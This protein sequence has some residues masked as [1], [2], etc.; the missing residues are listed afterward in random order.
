VDRNIGRLLQRLDELKIAGKTI[1]MFT[2]DHG[3]MIGHHGLYMKG[4]GE[5]I[6]G[7]K[8][9]PTRP[10]MFDESIRVPLVVRWPG[11]TKPG[12]TIARAVS[13]IDTYATVLGMLGVTAPAGWKQEGVDFSRLLRGEV[14]SA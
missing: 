10:N 5:W 8:R 14:H 11:V 4:N 3:Y 2:G 9:G 13:N 7:G 6:L 1:V 12:L